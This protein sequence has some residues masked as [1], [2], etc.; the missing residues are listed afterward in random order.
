MSLGLR[1]TLLN[2]LVLLLAVGA[3]AAVAYATQQQALQSSLDASLRDQARWFSDNASVWYDR[4]RD[5]PRGVVFPNPQRFTAPDVF[6]QI[7]MQDGET[8][9]RSQNLDDEALPSSPEMLQRALRGEEWFENVE[10]DGQA[11]RLFVAPLRIGRPS[12]E[13]GPV[14]GMIQVARPLAPLHSNL[15]TLQ[16]TFLTVGAVGVLAS[17]VVGWLLARAALRPIDRLA[18]AAHAIGAARD[19]G[20]RVP[21]RPRGRRD[22]VGRL[23]EEFNRMLS[24]LQAAYEQLEAALAAQRRFV[25]DA[26]HELRT[27]LTSLRGNVDLLRRMIAEGPPL[28]DVEQ[29][30]QL[31]ADMAAETDRLARLV[32][33]LLLL[34]RADA[35]Q[36]LTLAPTEIGPVVRDAFRAARFLRQGVELRLGEVPE[37]VWVAADADRLK[38]LLLILLDNALKYTPSGGRVEI[39][40]RRARRLDADGVAVRVVDDGPG[41]PPEEQPR[42]FER[43]Y[44]ADRARGAGGAGLGLAIARWIVDEHRGAIDLESAVGR[45]STFT[46]WLPTVPPPPT[47]APSLPLADRVALPG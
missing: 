2:G 36:H 11:L 24:Q 22:E 35:G 9:A 1:L 41:I 45:G 26:S 33:D 12:E 18:A 27:P 7:T 43:F 31:L 37:G 39:D 29:Q 6:V 47:A 3:Y 8:V 21:L 40:A 20:R 13:T 46:V 28:P 23:A 14:L 10:M 16:T 17:L 19:F 38:Q 32:A 5:R 44:R 34:A 25:A 30:E 4:A 15:H 42:V